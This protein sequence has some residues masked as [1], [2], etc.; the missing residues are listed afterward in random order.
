MS[1]AEKKKRADARKKAR[2]ATQCKADPKVL[3]S[4]FKDLVPSSR[5]ISKMTYSEFQKMK[6]D[7]AKHVSKIRAYAKRCNS[8]FRVP[9]DRY[10]RRS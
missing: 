5:K 3:S 2:D 4:K 10:G 9:V 7:I 6:R 8:N 1:A